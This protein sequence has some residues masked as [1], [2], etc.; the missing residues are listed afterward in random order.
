MLK[1]VT[2][3]TRD[4]NYMN[5]A[6]S[7]ARKAAELGEVPVGAV[8]VCCGKIIGRGFNKREKQKNALVH[9]ELEAINEACCSLGGWRLEQC[10][11]YVTLEPCPMCAGAAINSRIKRV[12]YGAHDREW[13]SCGSVANLFT[14]TY[15]FTPDLT[16]GILEGECSQILSDFFAHLRLLHKTEKTGILIE[17][18]GTIWSSGSIFTGAEKIIE[19]LSGLCELYILSSLPEEVLTAQLT[20]LGIDHFFSG[21]KTTQGTGLSKQESIRLMMRRRKIKRAVFIGSTENDRIS[22]ECAGL[23]Y[24]HAAYGGRQSPKKCITAQS[25]NELPFLIS[26]LVKQNKDQ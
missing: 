3:L 17:P 23:Q 11:L 20:E 10:E 19:Q 5:E 4:E 16:T 22:A 25:I 15:P 24:I 12:I 8:V 26:K 1:A 21:C 6:L 18:E 2:D 9:A 13:G 7:L 14:L